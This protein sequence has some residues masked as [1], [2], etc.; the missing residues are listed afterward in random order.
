MSGWG[1]THF[2]ERVKI[3]L[4]ELANAIRKLWDDGRLDFIKDFIR[5]R[6]SGSGSSGHSNPPDLGPFPGSGEDQGAGSS[7]WLLPDQG[8]LPDGYYQVCLDPP[9]LIYNNGSGSLFTMLSG[10]F[11]SL[12]PVYELGDETHNDRIHGLASF[13]F[14]SHYARW[15]LD[16]SILLLDAVTLLAVDIDHPVAFTNSTGP[17]GTIGYEVP[18]IERV[19]TGARVY[20]PEPDP[21]VMDLALGHSTGLSV[22][23]GTMTVREWSLTPKTHGKYGVGPGRVNQSWMGERHKLHFTICP[24]LG[25]WQAA[26]A[27]LQEHNGIRVFLKCL[28]VYLPSFVR[29]LPHHFIASQENAA[30]EGWGNI[31]GT[32]NLAWA[33]SDD[34]HGFARTGFL[35]KYRTETSSIHVKLRYVANADQNCHFWLSD[36]SGDD[37]SDGGTVDFNSSIYKLLTGDWVGGVV[38]A[39]REIEFDMAVT[40]LDDRYLWRFNFHD[41]GA[42]VIMHEITLTI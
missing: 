20:W 42:G 11:V 26:S 40:G 22:S 29:F 33:G 5:K 8:D 1:D 12:V 14:A 16:G 4:T 7:D 21:T 36:A 34:A 2:W 28:Q 10:G 19:L 3:S 27:L 24:I 25:P 38:G 17:D 35:L 9:Q 18:N 23:D 6:P 30:S 39:W 32:G 41:Q 37:G 31:H 15:C 13:L